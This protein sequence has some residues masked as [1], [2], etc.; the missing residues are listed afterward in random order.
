MSY[1]LTGHPV[2][3]IE[4]LVLGGT[5]SSYPHDYQEEFVRDLFYAANTYGIR[6]QN[7][8]GSS[9]RSLPASTVCCKSTRHRVCRSRSKPS[10]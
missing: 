9:L 3:K 1:H 4:L 7:L 2:D 5:W 8:A 6:T 10:S